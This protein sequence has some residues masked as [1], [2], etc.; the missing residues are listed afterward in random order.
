VL[1]RLS[2]LCAFLV[3]IVVAAG[4]GGG[5]SSSSSSSGTT[6][7]HANQSGGA[8][9]AAFIKEAD[10]VCTRYQAERQPIADEMQSLET[11]AEPENPANLTKL[12]KLL[13]KALGAAEVELESI[14]ELEVPAGDEATIEKLF[15]TAEKG[16]R[17]VAEGAA[18]LEEGDLKRF[19][20]LVGE[21]E[22]INAQATKLAEGYG[23]KVCGQT[24]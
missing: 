5:G 15:G 20:E 7:S 17:L 8:T 1:A 23:L 12:G 19:G 11:V 2:V 9:K 13:S 6:S 3:L 18:A 14:R 22:A 10:A 4:C 16:N 21:G 24:P